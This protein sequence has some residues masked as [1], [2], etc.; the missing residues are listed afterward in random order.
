MKYILPLLLIPLFATAQTRQYSREEMVQILEQQE[1]RVD[2]LVDEFYTLNEEFESK[3]QR[4]IDTLAGLEDSRDTKTRV[5]R[6]KSQVL[7]ELKT[8]INR[9]QKE[10]G[11]N[12]AQLARLPSN[13]VED[14][15]Q[16]R[17]NQYLD[18]VI[19]KRVDQVLQMS[20]S[21]YQSKSVEKYDYVVRQRYRNNVKVEKRRTEEY[22]QNRKQS[23]NSDQ[24]RLDLIKD[25]EAAMH[26]IEQEI[27]HI[28]AE[29]TRAG[30]GPLPPEQ[31][32]K[33]A[34]KEEMMD[35]LTE[36]KAG[37]FEGKTVATQEVGT[38]KAA[39]ELERQVAMAM[40]DLKSIHN[41]MNQK[42]Q[43]L[44]MALTRLNAQQA[45]LAKHDEETPSP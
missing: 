17:A 3:V 19:S 22:K 43:E 24:D 8:S 26:R 25:I 7:D 6:L 13:R 31:A 9:L 33:L 34:D 11:A 23:I 37:V 18:E 5:S 27:N 36:L 39:M 40:D 4:V 28:K 21:L 10:R 2:G 15:S 38:T 45:A 20:Q 42:G 1:Q 30:G 35:T 41:A 16:T 44:Q 32:Q 29:Q 12:A 14:A